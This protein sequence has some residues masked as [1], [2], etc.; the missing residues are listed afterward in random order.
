MNN[1]MKREAYER[2]TDPRARRMYTRLC[3]ACEK[4][5]GGM[6]DADQLIVEDIAFAEQVKQLLIQDIAERGIGKEQRNGRQTYW[7]DNKSIPQLRAQSEHQRKQ[8]GELK[9][10]PVRRSAAAVEIDDD[11][12]RFE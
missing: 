7:A 12:D 5:E 4:R 11:F 1:Q 3:D 10:T 6:T 8:L 2:I 9:L